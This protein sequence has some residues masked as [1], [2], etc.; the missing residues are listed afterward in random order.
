MRKT[1]AT[2]PFPNISLTYCDEYGDSIT[3]S[4]NAELSDA[5]PT[6]T[7]DF[8][9]NLTSRVLPAKRVSTAGP[10]VTP[11]KR[12]RGER[13]IGERGGRAKRGERKQGG[14]KVAGEEMRAIESTRTTFSEE[15]R[16]R[17]TKASLKRLRKRVKRRILEGKVM[18]D[19]WEG[20]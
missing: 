7:D 12:G 3:I 10:D 6:E 2:A 13:G 14:E 4:T 8:R 9:I 5:I 16:E 19:D 1:F 17:K 11:T 15:G 18:R 20:M